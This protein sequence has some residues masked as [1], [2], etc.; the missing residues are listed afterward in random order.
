MHKTYVLPEIKSYVS[1]AATSVLLRKQVFRIFDSNRY[2]TYCRRI[3]VFMTQL[4]ISI[5][6]R[7]TYSRV[8]FVIFGCRQTALFIT[9]LLFFT[10]ASAID[11]QVVDNKGTPV[12]NAVLSFKSTSIILPVVDDK[13]ALMDQVNY[14]FDPRI[15]VVAKGQWVDFPNSDDVRHHV[16]SFSKAKQFEIKM[17]R[18]NAAEPV[19][20]NQAGL[21]ILGCNIHD[22]MIGFIYVADNEYTKT[23]DTDGNI[24][25]SSELLKDI[26]KENITDAIDKQSGDIV[27]AQL[28]HP[29]LSLSH[30][31]RVDVSINLGLNK[32]KIDLD[33]TL[34]DSDEKQPKLGFPAKFGRSE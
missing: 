6:L 18:A 4:N 7:N 29:Q 9:L 31:E 17:Y 2:K 30:T 21:V 15:L 32:Q 11:I 23:S 13:K 8:Y 5:F 16:Y 24:I 26:S 14:Q 12:P 19:Q 20:F 3:E 22:N 34:K 27:L 1:S 28:W 25:L 10:H 33:F